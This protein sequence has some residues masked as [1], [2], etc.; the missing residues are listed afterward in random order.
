MTPRYTEMLRVF[1][2]IGLLSFGGPAAQIGLMHKELVQ[3]RDWLS[4]EQYLRALSFC[5]LL[6]G[7]EAMQLA[8]YA[9]WRMRGIRGGLLAGGLFVIPGAIL[10]AA[11]ALAYGQYGNLD[12]VQA[13]FLGVKA[14]VIVIVLNALRKLVGNA[15][16]SGL[17]IG[18]AV[19]AFIALYAFALP[20]PLVIACAALIGAA[21]MKTIKTN[22]TAP[23]RWQASLGVIV[24]GA[25]IWFVPILIVMALQDQFLTDIG[26]FFSK[27]AVV[28]FGG[29]YAVLAYMTQTVVADFGWI[30]TAQMMDALGLA[31]T[32]PGPLIL[33]TQFVAMIAGMAQGGAATAIAAGLLALWVTFVPC[34]IWIFA[35]APLIDW[36]P[37]RPRLQGAVTGITAAVV[38]V[39]ANLTLWFAF[40]VVFHEVRILDVGPAQPLVPVINSLSLPALGLAFIAGLLVFWRNIGLLQTLFLMACA[41]FALHFVGLV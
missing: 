25:V 31:E 3:D 38:G 5:M 27:L 41:G 10:I 6:P 29:A 21:F 37:S 40:H 28:S 36:L 35:G 26:I 17:A 19:A 14:T 16:G 23:I 22:A 2:R 18:I 30:D 7:P 9:G 33:V 13:L 8:T 1:G 12:W 11:L 15:L 20:F 39:F 24:I 34:F 4:Q 32:T